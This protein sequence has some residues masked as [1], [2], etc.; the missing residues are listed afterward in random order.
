[1]AFNYTASITFSSSYATTDYAIVLT[2]VSDD[3]S[4]LITNKL[5][6]GFGVD[7]DSATSMTDD[8]Y[9]IAIPYNN[10]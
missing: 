10:P 1:M 8:V 4:F 5:I 9:W 2:A 7:S 6:N 3:R